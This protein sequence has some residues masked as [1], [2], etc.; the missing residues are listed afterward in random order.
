[1]NVLTANAVLLV[2]AL[3]GASL[4][5]GQ[6]AGRGGADAPTTRFTVRVENISTG[7]TLALPKGGSLSMPLSPGVWAVHTG[8]NPILAPGKMDAGIGLKGLAEA[9]MA[10]ELSANLARVVGVQ[11]HGVLD[12]PMMRAAAMNATTRGMTS[13]MTGGMANSREMKSPPEAMTPAPDGPM[14]M[15]GSRVDVTIEGR[16]G[17]YLSVAFMLGHS[18]DGIIGTGASGIALFDA[19]GRPVSG[20]VTSALGLWDAGTEVNEEPGIGRNQG[21][22]QGA[23]S[24]GDPERRPVRAMADAEYGRRWPAANRMVRVTITPVKR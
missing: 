14:L 4:A 3:A 10:A 7:A 6:T 18:N 1:V 9:G 19:S 8:G 13:G 17:S 21:M 12:K 24:A 2:T 15:S 20:D 11:S 22:R 23:P 5:G 16:P